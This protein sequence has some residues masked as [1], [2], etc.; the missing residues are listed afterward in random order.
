MCEQVAMVFTI[1]CKYA[2]KTGDTYL[3]AIYTV[4][5]VVTCNAVLY[6]NMHTYT[7][8]NDKNI[9]KTNSILNRYYKNTK[10]ERI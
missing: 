3:Q 9:T 10:Y 5:C 7:D 1:H 8:N 6:K 2:R 4:Y